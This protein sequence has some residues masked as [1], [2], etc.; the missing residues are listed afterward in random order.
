MRTILLCTISYLLFI[1]NTW[2][3]SFQ[4]AY[5]DDDYTHNY[6]SGLIQRP[7]GKYMMTGGYYAA[8]AYRYSWLSC[9]QPDGEL[10]W[11][12]KLDTIESLGS[13]APLPDNSVVG[14]FPYLYSV[15]N[16]GSIIIRFAPDGTIIWSKGLHNISLHSIV[17][18]PANI[19]VGGGSI[20]SKLDYNGQ[21]IWERSIDQD[22][23]N[24]ISL[25]FLPNNHIL[26]RLY[27]KHINTS[28]L[29]NH[30]IEITENGEIVRAL[31]WKVEYI[32]DVLPL[33][34][35]RMVVVGKD[36]PNQTSNVTDNHFISMLDNNW[37]FIWSK[38][39]KINENPEPQILQRAGQDSLLLCIGGN[40]NSLLRTISLDLEGNIGNQTT[41]PVRFYPYCIPTADGGLAMRTITLPDSIRPE[42]HV[43]LAKTDPQLRIPGCSNP[44]SLCPIEIRDTIIFTQPSIWS[45]S[46]I[47]QI[48]SI[49]TTITPK[50][51]Q[52]EN[53]CPP[54]PTFHADF[55]ASDTT[56]CMN[57]PVQFFPVEAA[58]SLWDFPGA[59]PANSSQPFPSDI[60]FSTPGMQTIQRIARAGCLVDTA[61]L[62]INVQPSPRIEIE[63]DSIYCADGSVQLSITGALIDQLLWSDGSTDTSR[64]AQAGMY[65]VTAYAVAGCTAIDSIK[66]TEKPAPDLL[67]KGAEQFC[68]G[69]TLVIN[70]VS[71]SPDVTYL[72]ENATT[73]TER[74]I[75]QSGTYSIAVTNTEGCTA[76]A[77]ITI[78][79]IQRPSV[80][81]N[82]STDL[83]CTGTLSASSDQLQV[84]FLWNSGE[85]DHVLQVAG[86]G[87]HVATVANEYC[88]NADS[89]YLDLPLCPECR[90]YIPNVFAPNAGQ[91]NNQ[92][93]ISSGCTFFDFSLQIFDRWGALVFQSQRPDLSW[94]G[95]V[96]GKSAPPGVYLF[97]LRTWL[98]NGN[99]RSYLLKSGDLTLVR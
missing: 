33:A 15:T 90:V 61:Y 27:P 24:I 70:A 4:K 57:S 52:V 46:P 63:G 83:S 35:G 36:Y 66:I 56:P 75:S 38:S 21:V 40:H 20:I 6:G 16:Q 45:V 37:N 19:Y 59:F 67:I 65:T 55:A 23:L 89:V 14:V 88:K 87:W 50:T 8:G 44:F 1:G 28:L 73:N 9:V 69:D 85:A 78:S 11:T 95:T 39:F 42:E 49:Q 7:D 99:Q 22:S 84:T 68:S 31:S 64:T 18:T 97:Q 43:V 25:K 10:A 48:Q 54:L 32:T 71:N 29:H 12:E 41:I 2:A 92:F 93:Q 76:N 79:E 53:Y 17:T 58:S 94:N 82:I 74:I 80:H 62:S 51:W 60:T 72:W 47:S 98:D 3:Q 5:I 81:I 86:T 96:H 30:L 91:D 34:D 26:L 77:E 13:L